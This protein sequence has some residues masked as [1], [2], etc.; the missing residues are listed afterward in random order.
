MFKL[1]ADGG[2]TKTD[3]LL[4]RQNKPVG[5]LTTEGL[6]PYMR[7]DEELEV[8]LRSQILSNEAFSEVNAIEF[9]GAGCRDEGR[10][11]MVAALRRVWSE[12]GEVI[13]DSDLVGAARALLPDGNGIACILGTGSN[14]G[15]FIDGELR[16]QTPALGYILGD[17]GSGAVMGRELLNGVIKRQLP[18]EICNAFWAAYPELTVE[19]IIDRVYRQPAANRFLAS[20]THFIYDHRDWHPMH[21]ILIREFDRFVR[22][23]LVAY[24]HRELPVSFVGSIAYYFAEE[25]TTVVEGHGRRVGTIRRS[26]LD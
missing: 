9:Y 20:F 2:S 5:R 24:E 18:P 1:I 12:A 6:N 22:H 14:S 16:L 8:I 15:L 7:T 3:W 21:H 17:E 4:L 19:R 23:N 26:P 10:Q 25:L 13:V 11:R